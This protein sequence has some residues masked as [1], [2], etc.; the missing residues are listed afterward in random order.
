MNFKLIV[1]IFTFLMVFA[2]FS[3]IKASGRKNT[4]TSNPDRIVLNLAQNAATSIAV[5]WRTD[6]T[7]PEG[8][9]ELQVLTGG[10]INPENSISFKAKTNWVK[11]E[12]E[13]E[14]TIEANQH[15]YVF[16]DLI[17]GK[18]YLYRVGTIGHWSEWFE[19]QMPSNDNRGFSFIYFGDAQ[20][21]IKSQWSRVVRKAYKTV[22]DCSFMLYG[23]DIINRA[24]RDLEWNE[25]FYAGDFI[26]ASVPQVLTPGNHDYNDLQLDPHWK[27][28][29]TQP[30][31]GPASLKGTC[32]YVD[33]KNLKIISIDSATESELE[34]ENGDNLKSQKIW[35]D[36]IL[37]ANT[38]QWI[39]VT[40][41]LPFYST[42]ESRDNPQLRKHF[43]PILE[44]HKVDL[45]LTGHDHAYGR[46]IASDNINEKPTIVY[47][48]SVS[49]PK[50]YESG[51]KD[52]MQFNGIQKQLFQKI[53]IIGN[54]L[55]FTAYSADG[56]WFDQFLLK[57]NKNGKN[58][59]IERNNNAGK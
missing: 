30:G 50:M 55:H 39:I 41:H 24:G 32:F 13:G 25:W 11:Y 15:S 7:I 46:G 8:Y 5:T 3:G 49:G 6:T 38:K 21:D 52:W 36:S 29:F 16:T 58:R 10:A 26:F 48:V 33:Y 51:G 35:L 54:E 34:D 43:Q 23:G 18:K 40:T 17:P 27:N 28:Q 1:R 59:F 42:K 47:V 31:N 19:F 57:K 56:E 14:P 44:K 9:C 4:A 12:Y 37:S 45:V 20:N 2:A 53:N 22:P